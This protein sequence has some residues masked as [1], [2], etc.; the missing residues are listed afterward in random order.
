[1]DGRVCPY[2]RFP[3]LDSE[4]AVVCPS[5][6]TPH[7]RDCWEENGGCA[8]FGCPHSP[9]MRPQSPLVVELSPP[10][11][12]SAVALRHWWEGSLLATLGA[13]ALSVLITVGLILL[14]VGLFGP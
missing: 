12:Q 3:V 2:C 11:R 5:C 4:G 6:D 10:V 7:H 14:L 9:G 1:M 8:R 13:V